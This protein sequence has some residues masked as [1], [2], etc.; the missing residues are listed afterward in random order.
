[1]TDNTG[2]LPAPTPEIQPETTEA[3][4]AVPE[5]SSTHT[6]KSHE[7]LAR[8]RS[9]SRQSSPRRSEGAPL[10]P[11]VARLSTDLFGNKQPTSPS[12]SVADHPFMAELA[13]LSEVAEEFGGSGGEVHIVDEETQYLIDNGFRCFGAT[14]YI[15]EIQPLFSRA[16]GEPA[17]P[18]IAEWI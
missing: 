2:V 9:R 16:F 5:R 7:S 11:P 15:L 1:M 14:D 8:A 17:L 13:K 6:K 4:P 3:A 10:L 18:V 12:A